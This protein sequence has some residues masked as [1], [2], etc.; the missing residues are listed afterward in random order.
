MST[1]WS[2][3]VSGAITRR[4]LIS[5]GTVAISNTVGSVSS[6]NINFEAV[7]GPT[8]YLTIRYLKAD[9][10]IDTWLH[11]R[12]FSKS[13]TDIYEIV[14]GYM[15]CFWVYIYEPDGTPIDFHTI[16]PNKY[17]GFPAEVTLV[18][19]QKEWDEIGEGLGN[20]LLKLSS[21]M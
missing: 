9:G 4:S 8:R 7:E 6:V 15:K 12:Q 5:G 11:H 13:F 21:E 17:G 1:T 18:V 20:A 16:Y 3:L 10:S 14:P 2:S 19:G